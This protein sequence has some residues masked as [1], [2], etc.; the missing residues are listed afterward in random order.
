MPPRRRLQKSVKSEHATKNA[1][2]DWKGLLEIGGRLLRL[3][4]SG[5]KL[6]VAEAESLQER[7][8]RLAEWVVEREC[9]DDEESV[10]KALSGQKALALLRLQAWAARLHPDPKQDM[11]ESSMIQSVAL[12]AGILVPQV[13]K[14]AHAWR[15]RDVAPASGARTP[16]AGFC[17]ALLRTQALRAAAV[18]LSHWLQ[19]LE[20]GVRTHLRSGPQRPSRNTSLATAQL[21]M[22]SIYSS[23]AMQSAMDL[24][25]AL[26]FVAATGSSDS[27]GCSHECSAAG[28]SQ[29]P[30]Q[31]L[32][33]LYQELISELEGTAVMEH[34]AKLLLQQ[35]RVAELLEAGA[36]GGSVAAGAGGVRL[37]DP[38]MA[39]RCLSSSA[40]KFL[41]AYSKLPDALELVAYDFAADAGS[42]SAGVAEAEAAAAAASGGGGGCAEGGGDA[43]EGTAA[44]REQGNQRGG[45][46]VGDR[47]AVMA[48]ARTLRRVMRGPAAQFAVLSYGIRTLC[49]ADGGPSYGLATAELAWVRPLS[50]A[51]EGDGG[52]RRVIDTHLLAALLTAL[53][54]P[55]ASRS[56]PITA[57]AAAALAL[58]L[59]RF[60][61][62][63]ARGFGALSPPSEPSP[64]NPALVLPAGQWSNALST[65]MSVCAGLQAEISS[66]EAP[67]GARP[68]LFRRPG[69]AAEAEASWRL[70]VDVLR[71]AVPR[72]MAR[73]DVE[74]VVRQGL[75]MQGEAL[76]ELWQHEDAPALPAEAPP[77]LAAALRAGWLP[78]L[79]LVLVQTCAEDEP[80]PYSA[81]LMNLCAEENEGFAWQTLTLLSYGEL[82]QGAGVVAALSAVLLR[83]QRDLDLDLEYGSSSG[84]SSSG[85]PPD[86]H[87]PDPCREL[88]SA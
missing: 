20:A 35:G 69:W 56:P 60:A 70:W 45:N 1:E 43:D 26:C 48:V 24:V 86:R 53:N 18:E 16:A 83:L 72:G 10:A 25:D 74:Y 61:L 36:G 9:A 67:E 84:A 58:H 28:P 52:R 50:S 23:R 33:P 34:A 14:V 15:P 6:S 22:D 73:G 12:T 64:D 39:V 77:E 2:K 59:G 32:K 79:K 62:A 87:R 29:Q 11:G 19:K 17:R 75:R 81:V 40:P 7:L 78:A 54:A 30:A 80:G 3:R 66:L 4:G 68:R 44:G 21:A 41:H 37:G 76:D 13:L 57:R 27:S 31:Q 51:P 88:F 42:A 46:A 82:S 63:T 55:P 65:V 49:A 47:G 5:P 8:Q 71:W 38:G 85:S